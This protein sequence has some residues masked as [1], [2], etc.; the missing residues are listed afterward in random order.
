MDKAQALDN[1]WNS[2]GWSAYDENT[3]PDDADMPR[4][5]YSMA[6]DSLGNAVSVAASLWDRSMSWAEITQKAEDISEYITKMHPSAVK[7]DNGRMYL[8]KGS[9][10]AQRMAD[11]DD[12]IRRIYLNVNVEFFTEY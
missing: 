5:T 12:T 2:F 11:P 6:S 1:F 8:T 3:V 9:P 10:F 7:I 4:I